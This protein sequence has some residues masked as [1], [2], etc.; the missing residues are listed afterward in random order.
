MVTRDVS[1]RVELEERLREANQRLEALAM[2]DGLAG[3]A[4]RRR[5]DAVLA[6]ELRR[7]QR[8]GAPLALAI[9]MWTSPRAGGEEFVALLPNTIS[10][11]ALLMAGRIRAAVHALGLPHAGGIGSRVTASV[12]VAAVEVMSASDGRDLARQRYR[13]AI[14]RARSRSRLCARFRNKVP[15]VIVLFH[16]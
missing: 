7:A 10:A 4:N 1:E 8:I 3:L 16:L 11:G 15:F 12:G 6:S 14:G 5:F 9:V 2:Q 13:C